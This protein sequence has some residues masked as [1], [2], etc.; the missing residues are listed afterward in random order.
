LKFTHKGGRIIIRV[1]PLLSLYKFSEFS[2][3]NPEIARLEVID[4]G[5]GIDETFQ[6]QIF[7]RFMRV[8]NNI[9]TLKGTGLGLSIVKNIIEKVGIGTS[10]WFDLFI[11]Y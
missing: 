7:D 11:A 2:R 8:E 5:V 4:E 9:H 6:A 10:F 3:P 1:Y